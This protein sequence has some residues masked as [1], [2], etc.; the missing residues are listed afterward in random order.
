MSLS[1]PA[2]ITV[3][4]AVEGFATLLWDDCGAVAVL[5]S[6][7]V[8]G[9]VGAGVKTPVGLHG[10]LQYVIGLGVDCVSAINVGPSFSWSV[11]G[12]IIA[13]LSLDLEMLTG[14]KSGQMLIK[15]GIGGGTAAEVAAKFAGGVFHKLFMIRSATCPCPPPPWWVRALAWT[16]AVGWA[17]P[18][19]WHGSGSSPVPESPP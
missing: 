4:G 12:E 17:A 5:V 11:D 10:Q 7:T 19:L 8:G 13:G 6:V 15:M 18:V 9:R 16:P 3:G 1:W 2:G 14:A